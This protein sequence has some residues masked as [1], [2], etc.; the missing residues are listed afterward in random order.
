[1]RSFS[2][3]F[4]T[5]LFV[6]FPAGKS[7]S[8]ARGLGF[9]IFKLASKLPFSRQILNFAL[10]KVWSYNVQQDPDQGRPSCQRWWHANCWRLRGGTVRKLV[11]KY[12]ITQLTTLSFFHQLKAISWGQPN[13]LTS[14]PSM[15]HKNSL[16]RSA[17]LRSIIKRWPQILFPE[18]LCNHHHSSKMIKSF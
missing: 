17:S 18:L 6:Q 1:M 2:F 9:K 12:C 15:H 16:N 7:S 8:S 11:L 3:K 14:F 13:C 5:C 10:Q 4:F